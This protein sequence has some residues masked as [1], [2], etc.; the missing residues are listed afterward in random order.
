M[1]MRNSTE[2]LDRVRRTILRYEMI[3]PGEKVIAAVSGGADSVCL[4]HLLFLL[5]RELG[6]HLT[7]AH[8]EHGWRPGEDE[9]ET[10]LVRSLAISLGAPFEVEKSLS[11]LENGSLSLEEHARNQRYEFLERVRVKH[12]ADRIALG[13]HLHDQA[14]T[15]LM[16]LL[17]GS[18]VSGLGAIPPKR[19]RIIRPLIELKRDE[20]ERYVK[21]AGLS[22]AVDSSNSNSALLRNRIRMEL[23]P[24]LQQYQPRL[25]EH[26]GEMT[27]RVRE[28]SEFLDSLSAEWI[29]ENAE[30]V[31]RKKIT[32]PLQ[33]LIA[34]PA[35]LRR[36][37]LRKAL[38]S[39]KGGVRRIGRKHIHAIGSLIEAEH[40]QARVSLPEGLIVK[41]SY[42][43]LEFTNQEEA[44]TNGFCHCL[45]QP[46]TIFIQEIGKNLILA[47]RE[48][49]PAWTP[50]SSP[51]TADLDAEKA[52]FPLVV[53]NFRPGDRFIPLGMKGQ[54]K[55]KDF[56]VDLKVP[57]ELRRTTPILVQQDI[58]V[59]VGGYRIDDRY[60][61][62]R[63]TRT[64]LEAKLV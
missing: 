27:S 55:L 36:R 29:G 49:G 33:P 56:F 34:L 42:D 61:V 21:E 45:D 26:L 35:V 22:F 28:E 16:R 53:R 48:K 54:K 38:I 8:F 23:L 2:L 59:W 46:G 31:S 58:P 37:I 5:S 63:S 4:A 11:P 57:F 30:L 50:P 24:L 20:I 7:V 62:T 25:I 12:R 52:R 6:F 17:R 18:G 13:H 44:V 64:I 15:F 43:F 10:E 41:K 14:E 32:I 3:A 9:R 39:V 51:W 1:T 19:D 60:K 40:P 47:L